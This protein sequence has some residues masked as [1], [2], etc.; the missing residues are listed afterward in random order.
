MKPLVVSYENDLHN[1]PNA[2]NFKYTLERHQWK[3]VFIGEGEEWMGVKSKITGYYD[4]LKTIDNPE[5]III[6]CD[7]RDVLCCRSP[8]VFEKHFNDLCK[9]KVLVSAELFLLGYTDWTEEQF[10]NALKR[11]PKFFWQGVPLWEYMKYNQLV[12]D[13]QYVNSGLICGT[14]TN[15]ITLFEWIIKK[16]IPD[17]QLAIAM[18][19]NMFPERIYLDYDAKL[20]HTTTAFVN[21]GFYDP[22][23]QFADAPSLSELYGMTSFFLHVPG[24]TTSSGQ[25]YV[26]E[27]CNFFLRMFTKSIYEMYSIKEDEKIQFISRPY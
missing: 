25:K 27:T 7:S 2:Q 4:F 9:N 5:Q 26:Y 8:T 15:L 1:N 10:E 13:R 19:T 11:N 14:V 20:F 23:L 17:D 22:K 18:Y 12:C 16:D 3:Y 21:G 24:M 6:L